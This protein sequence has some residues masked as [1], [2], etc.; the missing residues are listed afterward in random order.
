MVPALAHL[1]MQPLATLSQTLRLGKSVD[2][3]GILF[4]ESTFTVH[5]WNRNHQR[6]AIM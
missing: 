1:L 5:I 4:Y 2:E 3:I 6:K